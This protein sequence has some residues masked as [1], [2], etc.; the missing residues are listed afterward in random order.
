MVPGAGATLAAKQTM[1]GQMGSDAIH[2]AQLVAARFPIRCARRT[3]G[4][5][6]SGIRCAVVFHD[7]SGFAGERQMDRV[8]RAC[9][10]WVMSR[11]YRLAN[12][13]I[14][15]IPLEGISWLPADPAKAAFIP[16]GP[17]I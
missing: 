5:A 12:R 6:T 11:A 4:A 7:T 3:P 13:C 16:I 10:H 9:Q 8:R 14:F 2:L 1:A 17:N 15:T